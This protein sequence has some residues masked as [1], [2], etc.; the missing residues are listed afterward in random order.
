[1]ANAEQPQ[2]DSHVFGIDRLVFLLAAMATPGARLDPELRLREDLGFDAGEI[3]VAA[4]LLEA[5][6]DARFPLEQ[7]LPQ[8]LTV[9]DLAYLYNN[10]LAH[11]TSGRSTSPHLG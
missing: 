7:L 4:G 10:R 8:I 3:A 1:M 2:V 9:A 5:L 11:R 6:C